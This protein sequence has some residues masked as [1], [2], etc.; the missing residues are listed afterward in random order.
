MKALFTAAALAAATFAGAASA[1]VSAYTASQIERIAPNAD[2]ST[3]TNS[4]VAA[5]EAALTSAGSR[6]DKEA[7]VES[8]LRAYQ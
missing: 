8:L 1:D 4:E 6:S 5:I 7:Q 3:L 2:L